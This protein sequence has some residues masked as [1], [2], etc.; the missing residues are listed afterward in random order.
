MSNR[1]RIATRLLALAFLAA[2]VF[3]LWRAVRW[4][5]AVFVADVVLYGSLAVLYSAIAR[6][7]NHK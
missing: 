6:E 2:F 4:P 3:T 5:S 7:E 1:R